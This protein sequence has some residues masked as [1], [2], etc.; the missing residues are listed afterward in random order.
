MAFD[1]ASRA[2]SKVDFLDIGFSG[3]DLDS[4][5]DAVTAR[6]SIVGARFAYVATPN[7]DHVV[8]LAAEPA[9]KALYDNAWLTLNDSRVLRALGARAGLDLPVATGSDLVERLF[10]DVIDRREPITIIGGDEEAVD[11]LRRRYYLTDVRWHRAPMDLKK[12]PD[13][14][15]RAAN[16]AAAQSSRFTF[17]CV[18]APQQEMIAYAIAQRGDA[19][20]VGLCVGA[21]LEFLAGTQQRAP[22]WM[23]GAGLE[24]LHRLLTQPQRL[25]RRYLVDGP[26]VFSLF[27]TWRASMAA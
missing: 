1:G 6:A 26:K 14:I 3:L 20:G 8:G 19:R 23:R 4:A 16:F 2:K 10:D 15:V 22:Q 17:I 24:W 27:A 25:W 7:V 5:V 13:A 11:A 21:G 18:G 9:R 12:K